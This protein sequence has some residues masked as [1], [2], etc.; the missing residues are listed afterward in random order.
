MIKFIGHAL[1]V[2]ST[3]R[4]ISWFLVLC[5]D[6]GKMLSHP[7]ICQV[8]KYFNSFVFVILNTMLVDVIAVVEVKETEGKLEDPFYFLSPQP[9]I[10]EPITDITG[11]FKT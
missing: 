6:C 9:G 4:E 1:F 11:I 7:C 5:E 10:S 2:I 3:L 8:S